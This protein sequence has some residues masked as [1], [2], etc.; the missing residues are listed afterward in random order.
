ML[1]LEDSTNNTEKVIANLE[2]KNLEAEKVIAQFKKLKDAKNTVTKNIINT[3]DEKVQKTL[4]EQELTIKQKVLDTLNKDPTQLFVVL[5]QYPQ[6]SSYPEIMPFIV[7]FNVNLQQRVLNLEAQVEKHEEALQ[8]GGVYDKAYI[9]KSF[10]ELEEQSPKLY[11][12]NKVF[13]WTMLNYFSAYKAL[14]TDLMKGNVDKTATQ[15]ENFI[16]SGIKFTTKLAG[17][18]PIFNG[19]VDTID[20]IVDGIYGAV[21][22]KRFEDRVNAINMIIM[23]NKDPKA[24]LDDE[25]NLCIAKAAVEIAKAKKDEILNPQPLSPSKFA[26]SMKFLE[27]QV[28]KLKA[29]ALG[30]KIDMYESE[31]ATTALKD[32]SLVLAYFYKNHEIVIRNT[33]P[34]DTVIKN[35]VVS[36]K[37]ESV[38][39]TER[40]FETVTT[41]QINSPEQVSLSIQK[42]RNNVK[43]GKNSEKNNCCNIF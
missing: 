32:V 41:Q 20:S 31:A 16:V 37:A 18:L 28:E 8:Y 14:S 19:I 23:L 3:L 15:K 29:K 7:K 39:G 13:Y 11:E 34:L 36:G 42:E 2:K 12:Y 26:K 33:G 10:Q 6:A 21:K 17:N 1:I 9:K 30:A 27:E 43:S 25:L 40:N 5:E 22:D 4:T 24:Q 35:I 38:L